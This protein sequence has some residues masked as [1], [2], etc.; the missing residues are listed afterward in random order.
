MLLF[1]LRLTK[2]KAPAAGKQAESCRQD[3]ESIHSQFYNGAGECSVCF[4]QFRRS[5]RAFYVT[6]T[7]D[8]YIVL[9]ARLTLSM[10]INIMKCRTGSANEN[11]NSFLRKNF[12]L[13]TR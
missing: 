8:S 3:K 13:Y 4:R 10:G 5:N 11:E 1:V 12:K 2:N 6:S 9:Y 7:K